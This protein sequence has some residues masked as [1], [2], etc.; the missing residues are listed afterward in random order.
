MALVASLFKGR[1]GVKVVKMIRIMLSHANKPLLV[2]IVAMCFYVFLFQLHCLRGLYS[3]EIDL[4]NSPPPRRN[5]YQADKFS[6]MRQGGRTKGN[7]TSGLLLD[8][9][10]V[11]TQYN[12]GLL[13][14]QSRTWGSHRSIRH[15]FAA[16]ELDDAD[17]SCY[18]TLNRTTIEKIV[19]ICVNE[20]PL[21][22]GGMQYQYKKSFSKGSFMRRGAGWMCAQQRFAVAVE[23]LGRLYRKQLQVDGWTLRLFADARR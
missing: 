3:R 20:Q 7:V 11:G 14:A 6:I 10:S 9:L 5:D 23:T 2:L 21:A 8:A 4:Y 13:E 19:D 16:T 1:S 12:L 15:Y 18:K 22:K 17:K